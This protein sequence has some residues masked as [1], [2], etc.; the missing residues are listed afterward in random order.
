MLP[1]VYTAKRNCLCSHAL[2]DPVEASNQHNK[3]CCLIPSAGQLRAVALSDLGR[4]GQDVRLVACISLE[5]ILPR[6]Q[7]G[8]LSRMLRLADVPLVR[9]TSHNT[10][11]TSVT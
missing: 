2:S 6:P 1:P 10:V 5:Q 9:G 4:E 8:L 3:H 11:L 7:A